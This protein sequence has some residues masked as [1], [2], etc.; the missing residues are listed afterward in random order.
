MIRILICNVTLCSDGSSASEFCFE[1][2][3]ND[4]ENEENVSDLAY[5]DEESV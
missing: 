2:T 5:E 4:G 3:D 1:E